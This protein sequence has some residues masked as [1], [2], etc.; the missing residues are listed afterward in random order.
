MNEEQLT[1]GLTA[2][3]FSLRGHGAPSG[4]CYM[5]FQTADAELWTLDAYNRLLYVGE[6]LGYL[7]QERYY[8]TLTDQ[9]RELVAAL[10]TEITAGEA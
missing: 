9:G 8:L 1:A 5:A 7:T 10:E 6:E 3:L 4:H 2:L